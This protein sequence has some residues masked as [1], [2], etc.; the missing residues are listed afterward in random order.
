M[1]AY[2]LEICHF[3]LIL[4]LCD[5]YSV[6][7]TLQRWYQIDTVTWNTNII[8]STDFI[9]VFTWNDRRSILMFTCEILFAVIYAKSWFWK[10]CSLLTIPIY[11]QSFQPFYHFDEWTSNIII[12]YYIVYVHLYICS[13]IFS[14]KLKRSFVLLR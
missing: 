8:Y 7:P 4:L 5:E 11:C 3:Q 2:S 9:Y 14:L 6:Q 12:I 1:F 13:P 10:S